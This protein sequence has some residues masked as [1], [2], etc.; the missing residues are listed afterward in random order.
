VYSP[1]LGRQIVWISSC[2]PYGEAEEI[3]K[4]IGHRQIPGSSIWGQTQRY[5]SRLKAY[6]EQQQERVGVERVKLPLPGG[7]YKQ[8][9][10]ISMD[11]GMVQIRGEGWKEMKVGAVFDVDIRLE[12]DE[13]TGDLVKRPHGSHIA[14]TALLGSVD[15]F[16]P[17]MWALAWRQG[18]PT[19]ADT[20]VTADGA[21]WIWRLTDDLFPASAQ[22]V[23]W[24]HACE[25]L[26][27]AAQA[28]SDD[29]VAAQRS[30]HRQCGYLYKGE[31]HRITGPLDKAGLSEHS[32]YF[33]THKRRMQYQRFLE[34]GYPI[35]SGTVES[36]VKRFKHR[37]TGAGMRWSRRS[38][39][40]MLVIRGAVLTGNF[41]QLWDAAA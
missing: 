19:A 24:Y 36:G 6:A 39:E 33:H 8:R 14:Y 4:R 32:G 20:S 27:A 1:E 9:M 16:S 25:H 3:L 38:A 41:D 7:D 28:L 10:G 23:D 12:R 2:A 35:G 5:G 40:E 18:V 37:V 31:I 15:E 21:E 17:A 11:G 22:I 26:A 29:A 34:E 30:F 13:Q